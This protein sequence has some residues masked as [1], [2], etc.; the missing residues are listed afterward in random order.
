ML[1]GLVWQPQFIYRVSVALKKCCD[2]SSFRLF[3]FPCVF[4]AFSLHVV[5]PPHSDWDVGEL[6]VAAGN[7]AIARPGRVAAKP[8]EP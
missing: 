6:D 3:A 1:A 4:Y 5:S 2:T 7:V 8:L